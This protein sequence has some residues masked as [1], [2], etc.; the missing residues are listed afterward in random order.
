MVGWGDHAWIGGNGGAVMGR[1][2]K[3]D[4]VEVADDRKAH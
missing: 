3:E 1:S 4:R 2:R